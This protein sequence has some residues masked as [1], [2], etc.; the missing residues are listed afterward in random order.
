MGIEDFVKRC[1]RKKD[2]VIEYR[3]HVYDRVKYR[4]ISE[5]DVHWIKKSFSNFKN[6]YFIEE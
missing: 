6:I 3:K 2:V 5:K 4:N 1:L